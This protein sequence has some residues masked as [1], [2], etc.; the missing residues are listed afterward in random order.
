MKK[1]IGTYRGT[2]NTHDVVDKRYQY[3][4]FTRASGVLGV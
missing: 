3:I 1:R 4:V 2:T